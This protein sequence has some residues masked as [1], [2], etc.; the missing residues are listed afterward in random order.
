MCDCKFLKTTTKESIPGLPT[1]TV[2]EC[3]LKI[4]PNSSYN[5]IKMATE[6]NNKLLPPNPY[7]SNI[8]C[9][10]YYLGRCMDCSSYKS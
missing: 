6:A 10:Y 3:L 5:R 2:G 4:G 7:P 8:E 1:E 9:H